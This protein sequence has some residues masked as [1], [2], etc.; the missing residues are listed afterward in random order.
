MYWLSK[1]R[2]VSTLLLFLKLPLPLH[3]GGIS[4]RVAC[5][6]AVSHQQ[7]QKQ[8][9]GSVHHSLVLCSSGHNTNNSLQI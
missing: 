2:L 3:F 4:K 7:N 9:P 1:V 6:D 8:N 5:S